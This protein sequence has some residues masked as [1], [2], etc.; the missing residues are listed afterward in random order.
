MERA[1]LAK[2]AGLDGVVASVE[3]VAQVRKHLGKDFVIV[4]PGIRPTGSDKAD[5]KR[6]AT[7][8]EAMSSGSNY[9]VVGRPVVNAPAP[10]EV[11]RNILKEIR[12]AGDQS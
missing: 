12:D 6:I 1:Q 3:E 9:L 8:A 7:P 11:V 5:Q 10:D 2:E 4:T